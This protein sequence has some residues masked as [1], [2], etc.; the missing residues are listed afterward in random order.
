[1]FFAVLFIFIFYIHIFNDRKRYLIFFFDKF[2]LNQQCDNHIA[3]IKILDQ[4]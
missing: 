3:R 1:M 2:Y 4:Q